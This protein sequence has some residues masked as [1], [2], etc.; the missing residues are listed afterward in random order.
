M[1]YFKQL[2]GEDGKVVV[3]GHSTGCQ[4]VM[5]YIVR[6]MEKVSDSERRREWR[7]ERRR[8]RGEEQED[9]GNGENQEDDE[10][11]E[12]PVTRPPYIPLDGAILQGGVSDREA[13]EDMMRT[14]HPDRQRLY[15]HT[16]RTAD[17]MM[18]NGLGKEIIPRVDSIVYQEFNT[19]VTAYR[20]E[21]L[22]RPGGD[23]DY[24]STDL[25]DE[26]LASTFGVIPPSTPVLFLLGELD[27]YV[28]K[29]VGKDALI[30]RWTEAIKKGG[31]RVDEANGGVV[32][33]AHHNLNDDPDESVRDLA[34]RVVRF[35]Q[36]VE[37]EK[38]GE[39]QKEEASRL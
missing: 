24:F 8:E 12:E 11:E 21:S 10:E 17:E 29:S 18:W 2:R 13:W 35:L 36:G 16:K 15:L 31:G 3:M 26:K 22:L 14:E 32:K 20:T 5:E 39:K 28:P 30:C 4:D 23:D 7:Q 34:E 9:N 1:A 6:R 33:G 19:P 38:T 25:S 37:G 27:P